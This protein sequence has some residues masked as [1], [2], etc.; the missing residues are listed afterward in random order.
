VAPTEPDVHAT[1][2]G[3]FD[4]DVSVGDIVELAISLD[5]LGVKPGDPL[6]FSISVIDDG[7]EVQRYPGF[8]AI[9]T[10]V[11]TSQLEDLNWRA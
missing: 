9:E 1:P 5:T 8:S 3:V 4:T 2:G 11:P 7:N 6:A 10:Q